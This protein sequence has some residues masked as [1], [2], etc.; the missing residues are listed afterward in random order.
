M[1]NLFQHAK[2]LFINK[3]RGNIFYIVLHIKDV[4][5]YISLKDEEVIYH[6]DY[7][8]KRTIVLK[9]DERGRARRTYKRE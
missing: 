9:N 2:S 1:V 4:T 6:I 8:K 3:L 7:P 5:V